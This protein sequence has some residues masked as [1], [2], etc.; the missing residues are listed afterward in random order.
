MA[1]TNHNLGFPRIG[2]KREL[3]KAV[4]AYWRNESSLTELQEQGQAIRKDNW[5]L[6]QSQGIELLPVGDFAWYDHV[7]STSLLFGV[8]PT[9]HQNETQT[10]DLDTLFRIGRG[11]APSGCACA[12]SEMTKWFNTNYHYIVPELTENQTFEISFTELFDQVK[13]AQALGHQVKPVLVGPVTYLHLAKTV[14]E[15]DKLAL[16]P[17]LLTAYQHV[18]SKLAD[19]SV[20]WVQIDEPILALEL[21]PEYLYA[22]TASF[23]KLQ[24]QGVKLL[25]ATYFGSVENYLDDIAAYPV[26]GVHFDLVAEAQDIDNI[27]ERIAKDK[28]LSLGV[29]NGRNI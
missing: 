29:I 12:A 28:V 8:V 20:E 2:K 21:T 11:R 22:L 25:L 18:L 15:F 19:L 4:E 23:N 9:R 7:L 6:Q 24:G 1:I 17:R 3:K 5:Q 10:V 26:D 14:G 27:N 13:E 16:L